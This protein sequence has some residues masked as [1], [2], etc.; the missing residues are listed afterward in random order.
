MRNQK[1]KYQITAPTGKLAE[2]EDVVLEVHYNVNPWVGVM[3]WTPRV[4]FGRW[5]MMQGG[6]SKPFKLPALKVPKSKEEK[7]TKKAS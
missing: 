3:S 5:K 1:P 2:L 6:V 4:D 7:K